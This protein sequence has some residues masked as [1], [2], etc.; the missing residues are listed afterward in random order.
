[1]EVDKVL[2]YRLKLKEQV[3]N[4]MV[5]SLRSDLVQNAHE[6][7]LFVEHYHQTHAFLDY[8]II[9]SLKAERTRVEHDLNR[10]VNR[11]N[12]TLRQRSEAGAK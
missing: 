1:M 2:E 9:K 3:N 7:K 5:K 4:E 11:S 8:Q 6:L 12:I 10:W